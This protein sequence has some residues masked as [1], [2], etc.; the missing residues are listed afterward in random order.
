MS[1]RAGNPRPLT[2]ER[3]RLRARSELTTS[4]A[5]EAAAGA[6]KTTELVTRLL[7]LIRSGKA[8]LDRIVA[9]TFTEKAAGELKMRVRE[10]I[11]GALDGS[12]DETTR[13]RFQRAIE[14]LGH[15]PIG[16]IHSFC[17]SLLRERPVEAGVDPQF[18][19]ADELTASLLRDRVWTEWLEGA[20]AAGSPALLRAVAH[21]VKLDGEGY[22]LRA[23]AERLLDHR[24][25]LEGRPP[26]G[27]RAP[28]AREFLSYAR[29]KLAVLVSLLDDGCD[30]EWSQEF[31]RHMDDAR[32][33]L[34]LAE[35]LS[36]LQAEV[37]VMRLTL[38]R[39]FPG[40]G[41]WTRRESHAQASEIHRDLVARLDELQSAIGADL[42]PRV[43]E[44]LLDFVAAYGRAKDEDGILDFDDLLL[45]ARDMLKNRREARDHFKRRYQF[46]L[47]DEFQDTDP[48]QV[49]IVFFLAERPD[50]GRTSGVFSSEEKTPDVVQT[51]WEEAEVEP[52]KLFIVGDPKQSI[53][54][55]RRADIEVYERAKA[56]LGRQGGILTLSQSFRPVPGLAEVVNRIFADV[57]TKPD[58]GL[59]QPDYVRLD[60][61]RLGASAR[62]AVV[63]LYPPPDVQEQPENAES[64]RRVEARCVAAAIRRIVEED[65]WEI[66]D[67]KAPGEMR[68]IRYGDIAILAR[69]FNAS[70][71]YAEALVAAGVPL[72]VVGGRHFY[73]A[74]EVHSLVAVLKAIDNP[75]D[76]L[77]LVA[78]LRGPFFGVSD[79][80]LVVATCAG[81]TSGVFSSEEK[82]PDVVPSPLSYLAA[83][84]TGALGAAMA[85]LRELHGRRNSESLPLLLQQLFERTKALELFYLRPAGEQRVANLLKIADQARALEATQRVT[86]RGF[87]RW[88]SRLHETEARETESPSSEQED[89]YVQFMS[90]HA[91]KGLEFPAVFVADMTHGGERG[92]NFIVLRD[93]APSEG[94]FAFQLG[95]EERGIRTANWPPKDYE[96]RRSDAEAARLFYV[97]ATRARDLLFLL[98]GWGKKTTGLARFL[99][100]ELRAD[101]PSWGT[102]TEHGHVFDTRTLDLSESVADPFRVRLRE[103][104]LK[105]EAAAKQLACRQRWSQEVAAALVERNQGIVWRAPS[106]LGEGLTHTASP[107]EPLAGSAEGKLIGSAVHR[108]L[109]RA[110]IDGR[111]RLAALLDS[112]ARR[113]CLSP[114]AAR[115]AHRLLQVALGSPL[116]RRA[117]AAPA[118]HHEVPFSVKVDRV[119]LTGAI[120][121]L[122]IED[123]GA[124]VVDFK[125]DAVRDEAELARRAEAYEAQ[126]LAYAL[127]V[128]RT[129][130]MPVR[131]V[132]LFFLSADREWR[133]QVTQGMLCEAEARITA[134]P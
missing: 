23:L 122:F 73:V 25:L 63:L 95:S 115:E 90:I 13:R 81:K 35:G 134:A 108:C 127:A 15:A 117:Q 17:A 104:D 18:Q 76:T 84:C 29:P 32:L 31:R 22:T 9:M 128:Q 1:P 27:G 102:T 121:L 42:A 14:G 46:L 26:A 110:G 65:P 105:S 45:L 59:Y 101:Q 88:L 87:V 80:E 41:H 48:L 113:L 5:V 82:T 47:V 52:G 71:Q 92:S 98:P 51:S 97:A 131:E 6:G 54:R 103:A 89:N 78:A 10:E 75:H 4:F 126:A 66:E 133:V 70:D 119:V 116:L 129:L 49:E 8:T 20:L 33:R 132:V 58:D 77:S 83:S 120:D 114:D 93:R 118:C 40:K 94:Q 60:P 109:E 96:S 11:E 69:T 34:V 99:P 3:D 107:E 91:A 62:P 79:D 38:R 56:A 130:C 72:R 24:E 64:S 106:R 57:I 68:P 67:P 30:P 61:Y 39:R 7:N 74:H 100:E 112:E 44:A 125:T 2:D 123:G 36:D 19:V 21:G 53:Y 37:E 111:E 85:V 55:F 16:T 124:V 86:F 50:R 28:A 43:G 12:L